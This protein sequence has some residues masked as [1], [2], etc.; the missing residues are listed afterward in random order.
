MSICL[1]KDGAR[2]PSVRAEARDIVVESYGDVEA[3]VVGNGEEQAIATEASIGA[4]EDVAIC[5]LVRVW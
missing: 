4:E 1:H 3:D 2:Y 5:V